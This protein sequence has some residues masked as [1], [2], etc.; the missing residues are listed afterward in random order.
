MQ[1]NLMNTSNFHIKR[2]CVLIILFLGLRSN[3]QNEFF[4]SGAL[5]SVQNGGLVYVQGEVINADNGI[6]T[7]S[8]SNSGTITLSGDWTNN[9]ASS[10]LSPNTGTVELNG[11]F[12][13]IK[14]AQPTTFNN[15]TLLG[16]NTKQLNI[17]TIVGGTS[18]VLNLTSRPLDLNSNTLVVTN[19]LPVAITRTSGYIISETPATPGYGIVQW[20]VGNNTGNYTYPFGT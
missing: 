18:G 15:L 12:Q 3:S 4:N 6:N 10:A 16:T 14:G 19:P 2:F 20:N 5:V 1:A 8:I 7:G 13:L 17:N 9:S 11:A